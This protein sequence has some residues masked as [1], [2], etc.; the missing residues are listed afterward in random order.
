MKKINMREDM[1]R[2]INNPFFSEDEGAVKKTKNL[3]KKTYRKRDQEPRNTG[4]AFDSSWPNP[5]TASPE[6]VNAMTIASLNLQLKSLNFRANPTPKDPKEARAST[7]F[8]SS[9]EKRLIGCVVLRNTLLGQT[10]SHPQL[11]ETLQIS[12]GLVS[13]VL[14]ESTEEGWFLV[15]S[16]KMNGRSQYY[17]ADMLIKSARM[18]SSKVFEDVQD[19]VILEFF[20][21]FSIS[22]LQNNLKK[23]HD[24]NNLKP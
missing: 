13:K 8:R 10:T 24:V 16:D 1:G 4:T 9:L 11:L 6:E 12:K 22:Q 17:A 18:F 21:R 3:G 23:V 15:A 20:R 5:P 2:H 7:Y 14:N 19:P